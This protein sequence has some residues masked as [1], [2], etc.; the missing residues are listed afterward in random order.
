LNI[1]I[2]YWR[3]NCPLFGGHITFSHYGAGV[4]SSLVFLRRK[5]TDE[6]LDDYPIFMAMA[7]HVGYDATGREDSINDLIDTIYPEYQ[8]FKADKNSYEGC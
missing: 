2:S 3:V 7:D 4:K 8:K 6:V 1:E 5:G